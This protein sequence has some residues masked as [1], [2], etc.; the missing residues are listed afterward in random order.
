MNSNEYGAIWD[1]IRPKPKAVTTGPEHLTLYL[2]TASPPK[3][4]II[5]LYSADAFLVIL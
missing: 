4:F 5:P 1:V 2:F 3:S